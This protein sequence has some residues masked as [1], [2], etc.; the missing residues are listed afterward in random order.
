MFRCGVEELFL[1]E[2]SGAT[3]QEHGN[4]RGKLLDTIGGEGMAKEINQSP[5]GATGGGKD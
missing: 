3:V 1:I 4:R 5:K 2:K